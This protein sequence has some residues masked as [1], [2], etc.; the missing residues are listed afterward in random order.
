[1]DTYYHLYS[2]EDRETP[3][4]VT[5]VDPY[6]YEKLQELVGGKAVVQT[7]KDSVTGVI[8]S[9]MPDHVVVDV[10]GSSFFVRMQQMIWIKPY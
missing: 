5:V 6:I 3:S 7:V 1:M 10:S 2:G 9:V 8:S 4:M